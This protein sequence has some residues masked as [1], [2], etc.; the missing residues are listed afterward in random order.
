MVARN[1]VLIL[2]TGPLL[3][4]LDADDPAHARCVAMTEIVDED[5][6]VPI[7]VLPELDYWVV[8]FLGQDVWTA[9][10]E[11]IARGAY[12]LLHLDEHDVLRAAELE[13][14]YSDL[15]LGFVDASVIALCERLGERKVATLDRRDFSVVKPRHCD[16]LTLLPD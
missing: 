6:A 2:D 13:A 11:D 9:F 12:R 15:E 14:Q 8:K 3:S 4:L 10:S 1:S 7:T 5:L 16:R